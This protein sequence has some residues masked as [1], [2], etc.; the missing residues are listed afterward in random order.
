MR[1]H[2]CG[3]G[4]FLRKYFYTKNFLTKIS[5]R[6]NLRYIVF[7]PLNEALIFYSSYVL[8]YISLSLTSSLLV[9]GVSVSLNVFLCLPRLPSDSRCDG[10]VKVMIGGA[11]LHLD[12]LTTLKVSVLQRKVYTYNHAIM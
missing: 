6:E 4:S 7:F 2:Q 9:C 1:M 8:T 11:P 5:L 3:T 10:G 12:R